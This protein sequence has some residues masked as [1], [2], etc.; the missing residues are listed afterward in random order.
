MIQRRPTLTGGAALAF[1][2]IPSASK[3][4]ALASNKAASGCSSLL[5]SSAYFATNL[6]VGIR[7]LE[8]KVSEFDQICHFY[9]SNF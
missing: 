5:S 3:A 4:L 7:S 6:Q 2:T 8:N 9:L 1:S